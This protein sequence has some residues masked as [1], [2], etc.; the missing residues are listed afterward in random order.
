VLPRFALICGSAAT[1]GLPVTPADVANGECSGVPIGWCE[2]QKHPAG[3][4]K[5][6]QLGKAQCHGQYFR[7][8]EL[9]HYRQLLGQ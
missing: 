2:A 9:R 1:P 6:K 5:Q 7:L 8:D 4:P 3:P